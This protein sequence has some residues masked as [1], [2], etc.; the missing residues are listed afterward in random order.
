MKCPNC[1]EDMEKGYI[2]GRKDTG[3]PWYP[4]NEKPMLV[5][6]E[7]GVAKR[8]GL[9][10]GKDGLFLISTLSLD[11]AQ[12]ETYICRTCRSGIFSY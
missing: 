3:M 9:L 2:I 5:I 7:R 4:E 11:N 1:D 10:L 6:T 12:L 8:K